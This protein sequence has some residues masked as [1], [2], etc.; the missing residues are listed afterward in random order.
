[1]TK[2]SSGISH[3][4]CGADQEAQDLCDIHLTPNEYLAGRARL[5]SYAKAHPSPSILHMRSAKSSAHIRTKIIVALAAAIIFGIGVTITT[6]GALPGSTLYSLKTYGL[7]KI[8]SG[9]LFSKDA[10]NRWALARVDRRLS[11]VEAL[12]QKNKLSKT[13]ALM[14]HQLLA[15]HLHYLVNEIRADETANPSIAS[16]LADPLKTILSR[17]QKT[18]SRLMEEKKD[19]FDILATSETVLT[20]TALIVDNPPGRGLPTSIAKDLQLS[21]FTDKPEYATGEPIRMTIR[22][23]NTGTTPQK[24]SFPTLCQVA[25]WIDGQRFAPQ[26]CGQALSLVTIPAQQNNDW[27]LIHTL[28]PLDPGFHVIKGEIIDRGSAIQ[29]I[30]MR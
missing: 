21:I 22:I 30:R 8:A 11:E 9:F 2:L 16:P 26:V 10:K 19:R 1:M 7:E 4:D 18:L 23:A 24:I 13:K 25:Y 28:P 5:L 20:N 6:Q 15:T 17:H 12:A 14:A 27:N 3:T 29:T